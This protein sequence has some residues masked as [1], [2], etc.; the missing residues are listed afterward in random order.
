MVG[1]YIYTLP[2]PENETR[3]LEIDSRYKKSPKA[4]QPLADINYWSLMLN[5][6]YECFTF[7]L[8]E[9]LQCIWH[10]HDTRYDPNSGPV[11][12]RLCPIC[13]LVAT[14]SS[15][16]YAKF[17]LS[18]FS[19]WKSCLFARGFYV[20]INTTAHM[21][22]IAIGRSFTVYLSVIERVKSVSEQP[23]PNLLQTHVFSYQSKNC[24]W[25]KKLFFFRKNCDHTS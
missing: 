3:S 14:L 15:I 2:L 20:V 16:Q 12:G 13:S 10:T 11:V 6:I 22:C 17:A 23:S 7:T 18:L 5:N 9:F 19:F 4:P 1:R 24:H 21:V 8:Y 25:R